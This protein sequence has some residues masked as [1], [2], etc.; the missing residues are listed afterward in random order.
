[1]IS[2]MCYS[3]NHEDRGCQNWFIEFDNVCK[4]FSDWDI[5]ILNQEV[6][7]VATCQFGYDN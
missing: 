2:C 7:A 5:H 4:A 1:M 3:F 6:V